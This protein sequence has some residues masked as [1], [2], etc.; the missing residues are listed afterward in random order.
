MTFVI[1]TAGKSATSVLGLVLVLPI[2]LKKVVAVHKMAHRTEI[3][4]YFEF[5]VLTLTAAASVSRAGQDCA[6]FLNAVTVFL[7]MNTSDH[8]N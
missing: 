2:S 6:P 7:K 1:L 8:H 5:P 3:T 4:L